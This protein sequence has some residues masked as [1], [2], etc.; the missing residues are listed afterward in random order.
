MSA[1][2]KL[3]IPPDVHAQ[4]E[5]ALNFY[6]RAVRD[7]MLDRIVVFSADPVFARICRACADEFGVSAEEAAAE[8]VHVSRAVYRG[9]SEAWRGR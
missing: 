2:A 5:E 8:L 7:S 6:Q 1:A 3:D 9:A 4:A